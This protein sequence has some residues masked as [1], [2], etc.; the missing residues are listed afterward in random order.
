MLIEYFK[1]LI[2]GN[3]LAVSRGIGKGKDG[4]FILFCM[5]KCGSQNFSFYI[6]DTK[7]NSR[8]ILKPFYVRLQ[9]LIRNHSILLFAKL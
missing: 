9:N 5:L 4:V 7:I 1:E 8:N 2:T 6:A 3:R